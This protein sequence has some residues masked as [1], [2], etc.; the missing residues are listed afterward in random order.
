MPKSGESD[1]QGEKAGGHHGKLNGGLAGLPRQEAYKLLMPSAIAFQSS[2]NR[3]RNTVI[4][5]MAMTTST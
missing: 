2:C 5:K 3:V 4:A 1:R